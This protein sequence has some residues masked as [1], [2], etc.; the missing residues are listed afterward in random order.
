MS[1]N[2][3]LLKGLGIDGIHDDIFDIKRHKPCR[4]KRKVQDLCDSCKRKIMWIRLF[5]TKEYWMSQLAEK[6]ITGRLV[7]LNKKFPQIPAP[8]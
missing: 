1:R 2:V 5:T 7:A 8:N 3:S 4:F 6:T